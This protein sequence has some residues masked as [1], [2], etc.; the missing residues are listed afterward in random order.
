MKFVA[1]FRIFNGEFSYKM[2]VKTVTKSEAEARECFKDYE[3]NNSVEIWRFEY[4][5]EVKTFDD[6]WELI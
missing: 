1:I 3:C 2:P 5:A 6:L 4:M